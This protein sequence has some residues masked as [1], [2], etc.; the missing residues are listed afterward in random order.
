[1]KPLLSVRSALGDPDLLGGVL[2]GPSWVSWRVLLVAMMGEALSDEERL[3]FRKLT[4]RISECVSINDCFI[5]R[6]RRG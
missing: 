2:G 3:V 4:D 1:M 5:L 6:N